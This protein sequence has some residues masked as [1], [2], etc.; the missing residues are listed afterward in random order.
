MS[1]LSVMFTSYCRKS[2]LSHLLVFRFLSFE[3]IMARSNI[4]KVLYFGDY[5]GRAKL[6][7]SL[8]KNTQSRH[9]EVSVR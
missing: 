6:P 3:K 5:A 2:V 1:F 8:D 4:K 7:V 9:Y